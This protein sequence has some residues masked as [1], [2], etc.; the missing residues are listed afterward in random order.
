MTY[1]RKPLNKTR[2]GTCPFCLGSYVCQPDGTIGRHGWREIGGRRRDEYGNVYHEGECYAFNNSEGLSRPLEQ[3][4]A[5]AR[6]WHKRVLSWINPINESIEKAQEGKDSYWLNIEIPT[7]RFH[8][9]L[10]A[11]LDEALEQ[12]DAKLSLTESGQRQD[13]PRKTFLETFLF[14][15]HPGFK[16]VYD[17][18]P[19][20]EKLVAKKVRQ[21]ENEARELRMHAAAILE[22]IEHHTA[23]P[24]W[25]TPQVSGPK[26]HLWT[27]F[28][29]SGLYT[30]SGE[31]V[32]WEAVQCSG[33]RSR[34][35]TVTTENPD[36]VTC[37]RCLR[38][39]AKIA[40]LKKQDAAKEPK[41]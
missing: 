22:A 37:K 38:D 25:G 24:S 14:R 17:F 7:Y 35:G 19:S 34:A 33:K 9:V 23:N 41:E 28:T 15:V 1:S 6:E 20:Y 31:D 16:G 36:E 18:V 2:R 4:D 8:D 29:R 21:W 39:L 3:T 12:P 11:K 5:D 32:S 10:R 27:T 40:E 13:F 30:K 26:V